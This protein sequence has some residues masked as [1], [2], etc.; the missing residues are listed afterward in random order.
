[1]SPQP[2]CDT[3]VVKGKVHC[4][5]TD[6]EQYHTR[7]RG[8]KG[9]LNNGRTL[10]WSIDAVQYDN[11]LLTLNDVQVMTLLPIQTGRRTHV[12]GIIL[13]KV[14]GR[15]HTYERIGAFSMY[16]EHNAFKLPCD[17]DGKLIDGP[18]AGSYEITLV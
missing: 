10:I 14:S 16:D 3:L 6:F 1:M 9:S 11:G 8:F 17:T 5:S 7:E 4:L 18:P 15:G 12:D 13:A 2:A